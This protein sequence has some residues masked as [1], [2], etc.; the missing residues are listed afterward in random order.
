MTDPT[1]ENTIDIATFKA[2][3]E[4][5]GADFV[6]ELVDTFLEDAPNMLNDLRDAMEKRDAARFKR[7]A[8]S[9]KSNGNTFGA[10]EL[11]SLARSLELSGL[12]Q[13]LAAGPDPL[14]RLMDEYARVA[15]RLKD[16]RN[17]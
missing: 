6:K 10:L 7:A 5:A 12:E 8:H 9:L 3:Q 16:L 17:A 4:S 14:S 2:L 11:G 1:L 13:A 15:S